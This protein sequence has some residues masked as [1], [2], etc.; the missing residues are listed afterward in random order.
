MLPTLILIFILTPIIELF[1]L[2]ELGKL[3]GTWNI[4]IIVVVTGVLGAMLAKSQGLSVLRDMQMDLMRGILP[5][6][7]LFDGALVLIGG[8]LLITPG[9]LTDLLGFALLIPLTR[10]WIKKILKGWLKRKI[11]YGEV[12]MHRYEW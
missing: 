6:D 2:I 5:T 9:V 10:K 12:Q 4:I 7:R 1:L 3:I 8:V 11:R